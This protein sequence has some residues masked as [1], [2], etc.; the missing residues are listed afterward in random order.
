MSESQSWSWKKPDKTENILYDS[1]HMK[2]MNVMQLDGKHVS[3]GLGPG[4]K[5][6]E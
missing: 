2:P 6:G 1:I 4:V 5:D 3:G